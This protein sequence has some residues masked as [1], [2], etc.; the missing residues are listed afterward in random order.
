M[1]TQNVLFQAAV[2][3]AV[4]CPQAPA[5]EAAPIDMGSRRELFVDHYLID[6]L[7]SVRLVLNRPHD[8][9]PV[10]RFDQPWEGLF[11][12]YCTILKDG[13][14]FK[15]YYRGRPSAGADGDPGEVY[16]LAESDDGI[17][18]TKPQS[19]CSRF[20][21]TKRTTSSWPMRPRARTTSHP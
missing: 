14:R 13:D 16:C 11:C 10:V 12:G 6:R 15:A 20:R 18:W 5:G 21:G 8:E 4:A 9:G 2:A 3:L 7:D 17:R 1:R 19:T